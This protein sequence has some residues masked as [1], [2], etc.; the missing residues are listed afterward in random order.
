MLHKTD[1]YM[2][3][4]ATMNVTIA[5]KRMS[6]MSIFPHFQQVSSRQSSR[7][8]RGVGA[9]LKSSVV[10][11]N[12]HQLTWEACLEYQPWQ[13]PRDPTF[14][15]YV[16]KRLGYTLL[17]A[18]TGMNNRWPLFTIADASGLEHFIARQCED[19]ILGISEGKLNF[20]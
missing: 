6:R 3:E 2:P 1:S 14:T 7:S 17:G 19:R 15:S 5:P 4:Q 20:L 12:Q 13:Q 18:S 11:I 10:P 9:T 8:V 16:S